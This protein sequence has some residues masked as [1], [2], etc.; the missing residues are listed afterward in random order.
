MKLFESKNIFFCIIFSFS[1][2]YCNQNNKRKGLI[3]KCNADLIEPIP[4]LTKNILS[5]D[6]KNPNY[7]RTLDNIDKDGFKDFNIYLD[8]LNFEDEIKKYNLTNK[9]DIF[10]T[11]MNKA[12]NTI[13]ALLK[14]KPIDLNYIFYDEHILDI[15]IYKW[16]QSVIGN[17]SK[18]GMQN[19]G[20]DLYIFIR[21]G[22]NTEMG[23]STL[24]TAGPR[25]MAIN[26]QPLV[27]LVT[28]NKDIDYSKYN[29]LEFFETT[30][31]HEFTHILGFSQYFFSVFNIVYLEFDKY[32][33]T[34]AYLNSTK[35]INVAKNILIVQ[36]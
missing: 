32:G 35:V 14:V 31:L 20:I 1:L 16:N 5:I 24:A 8:L 7:K 17:S 15:E 34:K 4:I 28:I 2:I 27:G 26:Y 21:F 25:Y 3:H 9:R 29:S 18:Q 13:K 33:T 36:I 6:K 22:N 12:I 19:L 30:I 10:V 23:E 11:G